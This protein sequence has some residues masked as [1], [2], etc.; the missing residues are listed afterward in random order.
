M[1]VGTRPMRGGGGRKKWQREGACVGRE[2]CPRVYVG[3]TE[4]QKECVRDSMVWSAKQRLEAAAGETNRHWAPACGKR[5][6]EFCKISG[7]TRLASRN[8]RPAVWE[9]NEM[10]GMAGGKGAMPKGT[11]GRCTHLCS[12]K[13][14]ARHGMATHTS[15]ERGLQGY[16]LL[17]GEGK[18]AR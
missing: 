16:R 2:G 5:G 4:K 7:V 10:V 18:G 17:G 8:E 9:R 6:L 15:K 12:W 14:H 3:W 13:T 1:G 11:V